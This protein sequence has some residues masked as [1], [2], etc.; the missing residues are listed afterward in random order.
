[1][2]AMRAA[3][4]QAMIRLANDAEMQVFHTKVADGAPL[5]HVLMQAKAEAIEALES[6]ASADPNKPDDIRRLQNDV[7]RFNDLVKWT[8]KLL[9]SGDEAWGEMHEQRAE[10][11][12][13]RRLIRS[14]LEDPEFQHDDQG[15]D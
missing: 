3:S 11:E 15:D 8:V 9:A 4:L 1:M 7:K 13:M 14:E 6:L 12:D 10:V 5:L 2:D